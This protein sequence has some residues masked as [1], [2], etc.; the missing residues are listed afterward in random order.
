MTDLL[1][2][3]KAESKVGERLL[4]IIESAGLAESI[5]ICRNLAD[6]AH[7][8]RDFAT[9]PSVGV[10]IASTDQDLLEF[11]SIYH[12]LQWL[13]IILVLPDKDKQT[14]SLAHRLGPRFL[15]YA[16]SDLGAIGSVLLKMLNSAA[17][18]QLGT[19]RRDD[20]V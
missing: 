14:I 5:E 16:D 6:L 15:T 4:N 17:E 13:R 20:H 3:S 8:L 12:L 2:Y 7:R 1:F 10:L 18:K 11:L 19:V 9:A